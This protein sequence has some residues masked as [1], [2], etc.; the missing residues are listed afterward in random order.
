MYLFVI[1]HRPIANTYHNSIDPEV[2]S[3]TKNNSP[4]DDSSDDLDEKV[5]KPDRAG[6]R[7]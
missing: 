3:Q 6:K 7:K 1:L 5:E 4:W 2:I